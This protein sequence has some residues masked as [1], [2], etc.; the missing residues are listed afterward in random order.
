MT[1][2]A[3]HRP[4]QL[5]E[6]AFPW[7]EP[8]AAEFDDMFERMNR[9]LEAAAPRWSETMAWAPL[10][11]PRETD[12]AY[13][14][15]CELPGPNREDIDIEVGGIRASCRRAGGFHARPGRPRAW[16]RP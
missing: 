14:V 16:S 8:L 2:P 4:D 9:F 1:L 15:E 7:S 10:A 11:D 3:R 13:M 5:L 12:E 6:R